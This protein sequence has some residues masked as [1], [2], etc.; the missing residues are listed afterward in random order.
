MKTDNFYHECGHTIIAYIFKDF[1]EIN[2]VTLNANLSKQ[3]DNMALGGLLGKSKSHNECIDFDTPVLIMLAGLCI[4]DIINQDRQITENLLEAQ[5]WGNKLNS[6]R[7][8]GDLEGISDRMSY[9][10]EIKPQLKADNAGYIKCSLKLV[11]DILNNDIIFESLSILREE[12]IK[13][14]N[15]TLTKDEIFSILQDTRIES[16]IEDNLKDILARREDMFDS[17]K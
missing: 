3:R 2:L 14:S 16:W 5:I 12:L 1:F 4:D 6:T 9:L 7:Y 17:M 10:A 13:S 8:S 11:Y 15:Q